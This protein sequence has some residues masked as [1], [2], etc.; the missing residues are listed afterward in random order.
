MALNNVTGQPIAQSP[1]L[2]DASYVYNVK[3]IVEVKNIWKQVPLDNQ[4]LTLLHDISF[5]IYSGEYVMIFGT[6]GSG[7]TILI[8]QIIGTDRPNEG[9]IIVGGRDLSTMSDDELAH[10]RLA[11]LGLVFQD[12][13]LVDSLT[14]RQNITLPATIAGL[15]PK[16]RDMLVEKLIDVFHL[17]P[18]ADLL[19]SELSAGQRRR[20]IIARALV[21]NPLI[22][23]VDGPTDNLDSKTS[24]D[25][26]E[27]IRF[28]NEQAG[29]TVVI[30][31]NNPAYVYYPNR[32][33]YMDDGRITNIVE[34]RPLRQRS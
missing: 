18:I 11:A 4:P 19:P 26:M 27:N 20:V 9:S 34:N 3:P 21:N 10:Y 16:N 14:A 12:S 32:V 31:T 1:A 13:G 23:I 2:A 22:M 6:T 25:V 7:K 30:V 17:T 15:T 24:D 33:I 29:M 5:N 28:I 8:N